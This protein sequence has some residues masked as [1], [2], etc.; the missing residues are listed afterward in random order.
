MAKV[1]HRKPTSKRSRKSLDSGLGEVRLPNEEWRLWVGG[2]PSHK[3]LTE[4]KLEDLFLWNRFEISRT[5]IGSQALQFLSDPGQRAQK[6]F[7]LSEQ[8][9]GGLQV[10]SRL[11]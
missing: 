2:A 3:L 6:T 5:L 1:Q 9:W 4:Q 7:P 10:F 8:A 11:F